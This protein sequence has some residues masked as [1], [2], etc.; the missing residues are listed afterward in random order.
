MPNK[1][2]TTDSRIARIAAAQHGIVTAKQLA[3][4]GLGR[5]AISERSASGRLHR[6][7][8]GVYA[9]GHPP[10]SR[11]AYWMA[12]VLACGEGAVLSHMSAAALWGLLKPEDG[13]VDVSIPSQSGRRR[14]E[15]IRIHRCA[16]L[17][18]DDEAH[19]FGDAEQM[20]LAA[21]LVTVRHRI[22]VTSVRR[23]VEDL[24]RSGAPE[25]WVRRARRQAELA[26]YRLG[27]APGRTRSDLEDDFLAFLCRH[28]LPLPEVNVKVGRWEV[29]FLWRSASLAVETDFYDYHRGETSFEDDHQRD[30]DLRRHG[31]IVHRYT[32]AQLTRYPA[33]IAGELGE[34]LA[35]GT[36]P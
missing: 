23:T 27:A 8:R 32:G 7:H 17:I 15:G 11:E 33:E 19:L 2:D 16:S 30:L 9:V 10:I 22:P 12:A 25:R 14:R 36:R 24:R 4:I 3:T 20:R 29:D 35:G 28:R 21:P 13:P 5:A 31:L 34:V 6:V 26:G 1:G 18:N